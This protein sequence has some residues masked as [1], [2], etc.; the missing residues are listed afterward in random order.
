MIPKKPRRR[1]TEEQKRVDMLDDLWSETVRKLAMRKDRGCQRCHTTKQSYKDLQAGHCF[2]RDSH[3][4]RWATR[5]GAG[6]CGGCH[7]YIDNHEE[8]KRELFTE[9]L[10]VDEYR[11]LYILAHMTTKQAPVDHKVVEITLRML[12]KELDSCCTTTLGR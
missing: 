3:T 5:N 6:L 2:T 4:T 11:W 9:L 7:I 10:G 8:A 12:I 1:R